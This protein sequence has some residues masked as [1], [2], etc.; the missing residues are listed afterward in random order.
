MSR[1]KKSRAKRAKA[2][3]SEEL[4]RAASD[5]LGRGRFKDAA[6]AYKQLLKEEQRPEWIEGLAHAYAGRAERLASR[7]M[8]K[9][10]IALWQNR[11]G[12]CGMPLA[13]PRYLQWLVAAGRTRE[14][15]RLYHEDAAALAG[16]E[17]VAALQARLAAVALADGGELIKQLA[18]DDPIARDF[19]AADTALTAYAE[20]D[21]DAM[22]VAL[23]Q[24]AFRSPY[25]DFRQLLKALTRHEQDP[26][27]AACLGA[28]VPVDT[29]FVGILRALSVAGEMGSNHAVD[30]TALAELPGGVLDMLSA[31]AGWRADQQALLRPLAR[32]DPQTSTKALFDFVLAHR[33][34][35]GRDYAR[36]AAFMLAGTDYRLHQRLRKVC[37]T[38]PETEALRLMALVSEQ[39][40]Q[41]VVAVDQW[42]YMLEQLAREPEPDT[43]D[44]LHQ[45]LIHRRIAAIIQP[46]TA[47]QLLEEVVD[48]LSASLDLDATDQASYLQLVDHYLHVADL[49]NA[50][51]WVEHAL[52]QFPDEPNCLFRAA[53]TAV[54]GKAFKK[55]ARFAQRILAIDPVNANARGLLVDSHLGHARKHIKVRKAQAAR[56]E[57]SSAAGFARGPIDTARVA[58]LDGLTTF[59]CDGANA[60]G[61]AL[62]AGVERAG[63]ALVGCFLL[64]L[65]A[66]RAGLK[67]TAVTRA[68]S[69]PE[70]KSL[71]ERAHVLALVDTLGTMRAGQLQ[72]TAAEAALKKLAPAFNQVAKIEL[73]RGRAEQVC[74]TLLRYRQYAP[75]KRYARTAFKRWPGD[76]LFTFYWAMG[77]IADR[78]FDPFSREGEL[79]E[80]AFEDA[81]SAGDTRTAQR[82]GAQLDEFMPALP[83]FGSNPFDSFDPFADDGRLGMP[84]EPGPDVDDMDYAA[85]RKLMALFLPPGDLERLDR[86]MKEGD[87]IP[88]DL[89]QK[90]ES[91]VGAGIDVPQPEKNKAGKKKQ[92]TRGKPQPEKD[93]AQGDLFG[94]EW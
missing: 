55:A 3:T 31:L 29:P 36:V 56:R 85:L 17:G 9:E 32:L 79:L 84:S 78:Y 64:L 67:L 48:H 52:A 59:S 12:S 92:Q 38:L 41:L 10:A 62:A 15:V 91:A 34:V 71:G 86:A 63:D 51:H 65:E 45:A 43:T 4:A 76:P 26:A 80:M 1:K 11:A 24:I 60:A 68:A 57:I 89:V 40:D 14:I 73:Q 82:I 66:H 28:R 5:G 70:I 90:L 72:Q 18:V 74:E 58:L 50:R 23:S 35:L 7:G 22:Q 94:D 88:V 53:E 81:Q 25:R 21:D 69:L 2:P 54:A 27:A 77:S 16:G 13:D 33:K 49:K 30:A 8:I 37:A 42:R 47:G 87:P 46:S 93:P 6:T 61:P 44:T 20:R 39:E 19:A 83:P 75:L